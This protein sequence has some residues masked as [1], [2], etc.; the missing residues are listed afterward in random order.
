LRC[1]LPRLGS[2]DAPTTPSRTSMPIA[3]R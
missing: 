1:L 2:P 3:R